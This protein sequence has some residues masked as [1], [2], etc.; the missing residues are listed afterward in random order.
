MLKGQRQHI[1]LMAD[2]IDSR[3]G[4]EKQLMSDFA[5]VTTKVGRM[6]DNRLKSPITITLGDEFQSIPRNLTDAINI[7]ISIEEEIINAGMEFKLR[8]VITEGRIETTI[9]SKV[10]YGMLGEGL[11]RAR[12]QLQSIKKEKWRFNFDLTEKTKAIALNNAFLVFQDYVDEWK[13]EDYKLVSGLLSK[14]DYKEVADELGKNRSLIWKRKKS[15]RIDE[16]LALKDVIAYV[17]NISK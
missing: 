10:G 8:Y 17:A 16:Y 4:N 13:P 12:E 14:P 3:K 11:T 1:I 7:I 6:Y 15:L 5:K 2:I 9:N